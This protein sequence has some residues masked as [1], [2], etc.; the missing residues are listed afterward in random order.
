MLFL[1][2]AV[3]SAHPHVAPPFKAPSGGGLGKPPISYAKKGKEIAL[4]F[5]LFF[6]KVRT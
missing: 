3:D 4:P 2:Q 1:N 5:Y 6:L